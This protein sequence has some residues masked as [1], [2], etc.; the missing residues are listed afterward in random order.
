MKNFNIYKIY[1]LDYKIT[2]FGRKEKY[3]WLT[4][5]TVFEH[6]IQ[7]LLLPDSLCYAFYSMWQVQR[8]KTA[9]RSAESTLLSL[10]TVALFPQQIHQ[11]TGQSDCSSGGK[12]G[13]PLIALLAASF[14]P[15]V[16]GQ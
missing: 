13:P 5:C 15:C 12:A 6:L 3:K 7:N 1:R 14:Q 9:L 2:Y 16:L 4:L 11:L 10:L 8:P